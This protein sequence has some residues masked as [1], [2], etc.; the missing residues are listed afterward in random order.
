MSGQYIRSLCSRRIGR[1]TPMTSARRR[2]AAMP[3]PGVSAVVVPPSRA[4]RLGAHADP[5][6]PLD[7]GQITAVLHRALVKRGGDVVYPNRM[8]RAVCTALRDLMPPRSLRRFIDAAPEFA[9]VPGPGNQWGFRHA[10]E[11]VGVSAA[12]SDSRKGGP[13]A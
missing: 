2:P 1:A 7:E 6:G 9:I 12:P 13:T 5:H 8:A 11:G 10:H 4:K 3:P